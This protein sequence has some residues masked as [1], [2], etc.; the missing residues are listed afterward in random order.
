MI[1]RRYVTLALVG[2][3]SA[4]VSS[5]DVYAPTVAPTP[6]ACPNLREATSDECPD[7][8]D[9]M[10]S[11]DDETLA[12]GTQCEGDGECGTSVD[13]NNCEHYG[14]MAADVYV[15]LP[16]PTA[17]PTYLPTASRPPS[18]A[19]TPETCPESLTP[20]DE[21]DCPEDSD[22]AHCA[23]PTLADG[24]LC[25]GDGE[26]DT[27]QHLDNCMYNGAFV[28][29][30]YR[31]GEA[32]TAAPS[33]APTATSCPDYLVWLADDC[34]AYVADEFGVADVCATVGL[35]VGD[36]CLGDGLTCDT[37]A[38]A[39]YLVARG[40]PSGAP[41]AS[42]T[43]VVCPEL[44]IE[45]ECDDDE[46]A[47]SCAAATTALGDACVGD[48]VCGDSGVC[49]VSA[50]G[51]PSGTPT[52]QSP[53]A[54]VCLPTR[55]ATDDECPEDADIQHCGTPG[56]EV[57]DLCEGDGEC[58]TDN[59]LN[60]C[61]YDGLTEAD[62]YVIVGAPTAAPSTPTVA[63]STAAPSA[64]ACYFY[65]AASEAECPDDADIW[66]C[67]TPGLEIG[68]LCEADGECDTD[69]DLNNCPRARGARLATRRASDSGDER[70]RGGA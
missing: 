46:G 38:D 7:S 21:E 44:L 34:T 52:T 35:D 26:C 65:R 41:S 8:T 66:N 54:M 70:T 57:G 42:P 58:D 19:P 30:I 45:A 43:P 20:V 28:A 50:G 51:S 11:C 16:S 39:C 13:L 15:V 59:G 10:V 6:E 49:Y 61:P 27:S 68:D 3:R 62:I 14:E 37:V 47:G 31:V 48:G 63:P 53:S 32:P 2:L 9:G 12:V 60:N 67:A 4:S 24:D 5:E 25:E 55:P 23:T 40:W 18:Y 56:L 29:D 1:R 36:V 33:Y 64:Q 22:I 69:T 17:S